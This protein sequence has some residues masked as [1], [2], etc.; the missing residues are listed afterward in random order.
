[1]ISLVPAPTDLAKYDL[2]EEIGHGGMATVFRARD[3]RLERDVALKLLHRHLRESAEIE[4]RFSAEARAVAKL[5]HPNIVAVFDVSTEDEPEHY[6]VMELV[7]GPTLREL[8]KQHGKLPVEVA[9]GIVLELAAALEHAHAEGVVHRDIK[10]ENVLID[11]SD[12]GPSS[13][14]DAEPARIKLTDF[15]IAKLLDA[16]GVTS[17]GQV[18]GS[19]AHMAPE[20]IEGGA[21]D[22]RADIFSLGV[23]F[24]ECVVGRL[25]FDGK[26]PAQVLRNVLESNYEPPVSACPTVGERWNRIIV[27]A[28]QRDPEKRQHDIHEF[29]KAVKEELD[30]VGMDAVRH[31]VAAYLA[32]PEEYE[33]SFV[34]RIVEGL[35]AS[36]NAARAARDVPLAAAQFN[37]ALA[38]RPADPDLLRH[39]SGLRRREHAWRIGAVAAGLAALMALVVMVVR[40]W[41]TDGERQSKRTGAVPTIAPAPAKPPPSASKPVTTTRVID[42]KPAPSAKATTKK[43]VRRVNARPPIAPGPEEIAELETRKVSIRIRGAAGGSVKIDGQEK[44]WFGGVVHELTLGEHLFEFVPPN[45]SCCEGSSRRIAIVPGS[46]A[47]QVVGKIPFKDARLDMR[48]GDA[49]GWLVSCPTLF[50][51]RMPLPGL[52]AVPMSQVKATGTCVLTNTLEGSVTRKK[53]VT[54]FAGQTTILPW[55]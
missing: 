41:P 36:G 30:R 55:P 31:E 50:A 51:G 35:K 29:A 14:Q 46:G 27:Q 24:Y 10:P 25:P 17:T 26:N 7:R 47:Q 49:K 22:R 32:K 34:E 5:R 21:V 53:V 23:L 12:S 48:S 2:I 8:L 3:K 33:R 52:R 19:P 15:G 39:V 45:T 40:A 43:P 13:G 54:L 18:L 9:A 11:S 1:M 42:T 4:A 38:Y 20:Q 44:P 28:L 37:R 6:L 16:Q